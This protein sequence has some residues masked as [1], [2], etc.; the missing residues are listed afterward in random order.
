MIA[1]QDAQTAR[2][3]RQRLGDG[4]LGAEVP[5][6][7][8]AIDA[9]L[10]VQILVQVTVA[11]ENALGVLGEPVGI[12]R[13]GLQD[14]DR[15]VRS[16]PRLRRQRLEE[17]PRGRVPRPAQVV[18]Q[19]F[20]K[21]NKIVS[22]FTHAPCTIGQLTWLGNFGCVWHVWFTVPRGD[23]HEFTVQP[24]GAG[25]AATSRP[26][27][28]AH[29]GCLHDLPAWLRETIWIGSEEVVDTSPGEA[30]ASTKHRRD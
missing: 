17:R 22:A 8:H 29:R 19:L 12:V 16:S 6:A 13:G 25:S 30:Y 27:I 5:D 18:R 1:S 7:R 2:V 4:K 14:G 23:P 20:E 15:V 24:T 28:Q 26:T 10:A 3:D 9:W 21:R 11:L